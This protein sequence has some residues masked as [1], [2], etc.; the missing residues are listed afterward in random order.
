VILGFET[1]SALMAKWGDASIRRPTFETLRTN[2]SITMEHNK[3]GFA[4]LLTPHKEDGGRD[5]SRKIMVFVRTDVMVIE[6]P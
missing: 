5:F 2:T 4:G 6:N 3:F 1:N